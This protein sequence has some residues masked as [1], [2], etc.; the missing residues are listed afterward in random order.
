[1]LV[2]VGGN[3]GDLSNLLGGGD[4]A[5]ILTQEADN[6]VNGGLGTSSEIHRV[7]A[8]SNV[9]NG[10]SENSTAKDSSRS[11]TITS[12][13]VGLGSNLLQETGTQ[14]LE[15]VLQ[16][17]GLGNGNTI[18]GDLGSTKGLL[19]KNIATLGAEGNRDSLGQSVN[20]LEE[21]GTA[22]N[23]KLELLGGVDRVV[24]ETR[25]DGRSNRR[26]N[27]SRLHFVVF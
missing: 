5:L 21:S 3:G 25:F 16:V 8:S 10:L 17:D 20:T 7:A 18:L 11:G 14:V 24:S 26:L 13:F 12:R 23:A 15:L 4:L 9:L 6:G 19:N 1:V 22:L 27:K 2:T